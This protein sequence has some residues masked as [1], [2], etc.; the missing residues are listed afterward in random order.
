MVEICS[1]TFILSRLRRT[2]E[3][4]AQQPL[5]FSEWPDDL[6]TASQVVFRPLFLYKHKQEEK[7][8]NNEQKRK[9]QEEQ[10]ELHLLNHPQYVSTAQHYLYDPYY[11]YYYQ[12][13]YNRPEH[14]INHATNVNYLSNNDIRRQQ[15]T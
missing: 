4:Q 12:Q 7:R 11:Y 14:F 2:P 13:F 10:L 5:P 8:I 6:D 1:N 3:K 9:E 15:K